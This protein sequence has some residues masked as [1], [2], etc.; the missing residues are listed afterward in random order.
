MPC[1]T[2]HYDG[3]K[4]T[5]RLARGSHSIE[6]AFI[7]GDSGEKNARTRAS[8]FFHAV[9]RVGGRTLVWHTRMEYHHK[10]P[11]GIDCLY[12]R[13]LS[14][15]S[16]DVARVFND[17]D[18]VYCL[19]LRKTSSTNFRAENEGSKAIFPSKRPPTHAILILGVH[20][21][22]QIFIWVNRRTTTR[23]CHI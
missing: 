18:Y 13:F 7:R 11:A 12:A 2:F 23:S 20:N 17:T 3:Q 9:R 21:N 14:L 1:V 16:L 19:S 4:P 6:Y 5:E 15:F 8:F 22:P 10:T